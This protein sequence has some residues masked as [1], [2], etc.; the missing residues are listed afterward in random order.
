MNALVLAHAAATLAMVGVILVVQLVHY[1][2]FDHVDVARFAAFEAQHS[3]RITYIV[4]P[5]M[6]LELVTALAL[7]AARPAWLPAWMAWAG[8]ALVGVIWLSTAV[9][10]VPLHRAL[11]S[12]FDATAHARLVATNW[13]RTLAWLVRAALVVGMLSRWHGAAA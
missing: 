12:G 1:P 4:L 13:I 10:Q 6:G 11:A 9:V 5:L 3:R 7:A 8:L 2:L